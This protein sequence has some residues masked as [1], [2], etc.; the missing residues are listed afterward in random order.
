MRSLAS[1]TGVSPGIDA[2]SC[3][4]SHRP[5]QS[6]AVTPSIVQFV[7]VSLRPVNPS[8]TPAINGAP[9][10]DQPYVVKVG[11][12]RT[13]SQRIAA[14]RGFL[15]CSASQ[16]FWVLDQN[17]AQPDSSLRAQDREFLHRKSPRCKVASCNVVYRASPQINRHSSHDQTGKGLAVNPLLTGRKTVTSINNMEATW[18]TQGFYPFALIASAKVM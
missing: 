2:T 17:P 13:V 3:F 6:L 14:C 11:N 16:S 15:S 12:F 10:P 7:Q 1:T 9:Q 5:S 18:K 4:L 8:P